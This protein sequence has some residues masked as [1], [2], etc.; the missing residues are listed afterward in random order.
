MIIPTFGRGEKLARCVRALAAQSFPQNRYEVLVGFD[1]PDPQGRHMALEAWLGVRG[2]EQG[3]VLVDCERLGLNATRNRVLHEA[4]GRILVSTNDD[5]VPDPDFLTAHARAHEEA[6]PRFPQ[7]V[8][9]SGHSP[10]ADVRSPTL[11][12]RLCADT[13]MVFFFDQMIGPEAQPG[14]NDRWRDWG[15]RH[16]WGLNFSAPMA[17]VRDG[18]GFVAFPMAYGYDDIEL[19]WRLERHH[20][21]PVLFRPEARAVH[22]H[23]MTPR[24]VLD[25][26]H[27]LG[28]SAWRF[29]GASPDFARA[30]FGRDL[31]SSDEINYSREFVARERG[32]AER[33]ER[34]FVGT[35]EIPAGPL[36]TLGPAASRQ[37]VRL[38]YEHH[39]LLK[40]WYWRRGLLEAVGLG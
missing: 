29:A 16:C 38:A 30:V 34:S 26:E 20:A 1:G 13:S 17:P 10:F 12:D 22:D 28:H 36:D 15:F 6:H 3:L 2:H 27:R 31:R 8:I 32:T 7:G 9:V 40:R 23:R 19:A 33:L 21:M 37:I 5:T 11:F 25:R 18:D 14:A 35:S 39:L 4:R 24:E